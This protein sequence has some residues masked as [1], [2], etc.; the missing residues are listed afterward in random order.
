MT[1]YPRSV[2]VATVEAAFGMKLDAL[3][4]DFSEAVAAASIAQV[5]RARVVDGE[6]TEW[7]KVAL[8]RMLAIT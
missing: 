3:F 5:H 7:A 1:P 8:E 2:A 6:T 4:I